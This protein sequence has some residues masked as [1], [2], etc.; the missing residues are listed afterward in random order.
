L[1]FGDAGIFTDLP[2]A[3]S[4]EQIEALLSVPAGDGNLAKAS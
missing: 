1:L 4:V 2:Q 3:T